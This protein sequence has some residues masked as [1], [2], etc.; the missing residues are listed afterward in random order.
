MMLELDRVSYRYASGAEALRGVSFGVREGEL[1]A[2]VGP[3]GS[4]KSTLARLIARV[5]EPLSGELRFGGRPLQS[6]NAKE[7]ARAVGYLPQELEAAVP[8]TARQVVESGR[9]PF[10]DRFAWE[11]ERDRALATEALARCDASHLERR[12]VGEMSGGERKRVFLSRVFAGEPRLMVLDEPFA[13]VDLAHIQQITS[14]LKGSGCAV[15]VVSH[16]V[17][18]AASA[19]DRV[20]V[21]SR[22]KVAADGAPAEVVTTSLME[23]VFGID[24]EAVV[25]RNGKVAVLPSFDGDDLR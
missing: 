23:Q 1:V 20:I 17:N 13:A 11:S 2:L 16:D 14:V 8:M 5:I 19:S 9:A 24:C 12:L 10:L 21:M 7:Y 22:G 15:L 6:W 18:W 25:L 4:G 3:N